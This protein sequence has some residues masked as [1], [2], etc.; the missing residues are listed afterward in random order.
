MFSGGQL[1]IAVPHWVLRAGAAVGSD[2]ASYQTGAHELVDGKVHDSIFNARDV[3]GLLFLEEP[4]C[5]SRVDIT[6]GER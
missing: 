1:E 2:A 4:R 3:Q 6:P 5:I